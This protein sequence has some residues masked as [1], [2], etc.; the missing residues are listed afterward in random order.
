MKRIS[1]KIFLTLISLVGTDATEISSD[2][3]FAHK[4][5]PMFKAKCLACHGEDPKKIKGDF[6]MR[7]YSG[8]LRGGES[9]EPSVVPG[10]PLQ[11]PLYMAV[12]RDHEDQWE[13]MPPKE[14]DKL[15]TEQTDHIRNWI[16]GGAPWPGPESLSKL[17]KEKD[18]WSADGSVKV[19]TSGGLSEDWT[20]RKYEE[21][22]LWAY[23]PI[24]KPNLRTND[25][26]VDALIRARSPEG[27]SVA[28]SAEALTLIRRVTFDLTG[29]PPKPREVQAFKMAWEKDRDGAWEDLIDQLLASP[30]Y[31]EQMA[32][33]WLD[34][35]RYADSAGFSNDYPRPH[36]WR[37]RDYVVRS[38]NND[39]P[40][41]QFVREQIAG[42][43]IKPKDPDHL[44][45]TGFLRMGPWEHTAMSVKAVT[46]QQYLDDV[47]NSVGVTFLAN[48]LR[49]AKCHDHKFDPIP[50]RDYYRM[51]AIFAPV[52]FSERKLPWQD[53]ENRI[54]I[55]KDH[56]R[57]QRLIKEKGIR[58][59]TSLPEADRP[60]SQ[61][62][63]ESERAGH[64]KV[65]NKRR[66]QLNY[67][68]K[69]ANPSV[70]SVINGAP[71]K[72]HILKGGSIESPQE[73]VSPGILSLFEG[74]EELASLTNNKNGRRKELAK[75]ITS[76]NNPLTARVIVNRIWQWHFGQ[77][78]AGNPNNFGGT[79]KFPTHPELLDWLA[80]TFIEGD[81]SVK[82][83]H[84]YILTSATYQ[85]SAS[86]PDPQALARLDP[87]NISY[88]S[89]K[90]RKLTA[91]ELRDSMLAVSGE[92]NPTLGGIPCHPEINE[93]IAM[94]PRHIMGSVGPAYQADPLPSQRNRRTLYAE[95]IRTLADPMLEVFN[96]PGPD[97]SCERRET[98]TI[99]PQAFTM[100]NSPIIRSRA[101]AF[102]AR[103][104]KERPG[105][106][107]E[108]VRRAFQL[109]YHRMPHDIEMKM[110]LE[111]LANSKKEHEANQ[112]ERVELPKYVV[113]QMVEEM[114]GQAFWW[115][116]DLDIYAGPD[117][118]SD[119]K[120]WDVGSDTR[121]LGDLC[122]VLFNSNEFI[123]IY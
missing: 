23:Q 55:K 13:P 64:S 83:I 110:S 107:N 59:I 95:R 100:L 56:E 41:D 91:E 14:N 51:Q 25:H 39:K 108:Q 85:R 112:Q 114:T 46:R 28:L 54:G 32:R 81:W 92:L 34:V 42:D 44:I 122:L 21:S 11:S 88:A 87:E 12:K 119:L 105:N 72:I 101:L 27:L 62:D 63:K 45:A 89:F 120:P 16:E 79:G 80:A 118:V 36:A 68:L 77:G 109:T 57:Y 78:L 1:T 6:D 10:K 67:Q 111:Y 26:P 65:N 116:E 71:D 74:S 66:Q 40:Y 69:R 60:V 76:K 82:K 97:L 20:N 121:A 61:F 5:L 58:S 31:G 115:V 106:I 19:K 53:F 99:A 22:K 70:F 43:E 48:E 52:T 15:S 35:V 102:A 98:A 93:E 17:L 24:S 84:R 50:T 7:T 73:E 2:M 90:P 9:E 3:L 117:Y 123:Y 30:H 49:C 75:W 103:L 37:Y 8:L 94:Q 86:H 96:K 38:F 104:Q 18:P 29:L 47:V 33:H 113:R 4:I